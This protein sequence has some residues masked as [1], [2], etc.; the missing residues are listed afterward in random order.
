MK[1]A[2]IQ[3]ANYVMH[4]QS[5]GSCHMGWDRVLQYYLEF[6]CLNYRYNI[7]LTYLRGKAHLKPLG[8][9]S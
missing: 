7:I 1:P 3:F 6:V 9:T 8:F 5:S 2:Y 4:S